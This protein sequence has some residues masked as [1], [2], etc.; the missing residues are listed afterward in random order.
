MQQRHQGE[1]DEA[2]ERRGCVAID[3]KT[4]QAAEIK[5]FLNKA[6][7]F[8]EKQKLQD[9]PQRQPATGYCKPP[10]RLWRAL[11]TIENHKTGHEDP[12]GQGSAQ[13]AEFIIRRSE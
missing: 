12:E 8:R 4:G 2:E 10:Q 9:A 6:Q 13:K 5:A 11:V 7:H 1:K 3:E